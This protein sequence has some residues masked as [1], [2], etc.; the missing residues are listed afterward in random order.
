MTIAFEIFVNGEQC[1]T[2][3]GEDY[4]CFN[5]L[6]TLLRPPLPKPDDM[7]IDLATACITTD[8]SRV[9]MWSSLSLQVGDRVE[10]R[11]VDV[12]TI[13]EPESMQI[14]EIGNENVGS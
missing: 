3:G 1:L 4:S 11:I 2:I 5:V 10:I 7:R 9:G 13:D 14:L 8:Q 12:E 6:L